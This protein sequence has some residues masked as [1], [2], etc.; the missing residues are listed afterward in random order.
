VDCRG[1]FGAEVRSSGQELRE[2]GS[3]PRRDVYEQS[4]A[5]GRG[6]NLVDEG[7]AGK[8]EV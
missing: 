3:I 5:I 4:A 1:D 2:G 6:Q 8:D 7:V